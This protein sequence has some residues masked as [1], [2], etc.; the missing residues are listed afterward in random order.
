MN[1]QQIKRNMSKQNRSKITLK[2]LN[3]I[4]RGIREAIA[5]TKQ[6]GS[7]GIKKIQQTT[8]YYNRVKNKVID[9][10]AQPKKFLKP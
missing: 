6:E 4:V 2:I 5:C 3:I 7:L 10:E 1:R 9:R 8:T